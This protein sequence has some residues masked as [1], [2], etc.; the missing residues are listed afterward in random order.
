MISKFFNRNLFD[1]FEDFQFIQK[2]TGQDM[3]G[4]DL[5]KRLEAAGLPFSVRD[6]ICVETFGLTADMVR[7]A[8]YAGYK[9]G[10]NP[11]LLLLAADDAKDGE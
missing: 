5:D 6:P 10:R 7:A 2:L 11:D 3:T 9:V 8:F 1:S 4:P